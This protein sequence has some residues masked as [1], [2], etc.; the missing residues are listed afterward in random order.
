MNAI[1]GGNMDCIERKGHSLIQHGKENNR[2]YLMKYN[3]RDQDTLL[4][5]LDDLASENGY[6]KIFAKVPASVH[7]LFV[8]NGYEPEA[9]I[10][11]FFDGKEA[12][13][14]MAKYFVQERKVID[15]NVL[16]D[17]S[18]LLSGPVSNNGK[19]LPSRFRIDI[20]EPTHCGEMARL[21]REVFETYPFPVMDAGYL[22]KT[23]D[24]Q[25]V[26][27]FGIRDQGQLI[28]LSSAELDTTNKNA[29]MTD[30]AVLPAY[31]G[32]N[33]AGFLLEKMET[34][35]K[36]QHFKTLFTIARLNSPGMNK[37]FI[38][39]GYL[40]SGLLKNNTNISGKIESMCVYYKNM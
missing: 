9:W 1:T 7:P 14:F 18:E 34:E 15:R 29:E 33:L 11:G 31:R 4:V 28:G 39:Q 13:F 19:N 22:R 30:F 12:V 5:Q 20:A 17:F 6:S 37:T 3:S 23:M 8:Q 25:S 24:D 35:M 27:Y 40:Y 21:Y 10:P 32:K 16:P 2:I 26:I 38:K 36:R